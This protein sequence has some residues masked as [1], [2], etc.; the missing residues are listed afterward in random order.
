VKLGLK[1][2]TVVCSDFL[3]AKRELLNDMINKVNRVSLCMFGVNF[4]CSDPG[5]IVDRSILEASGFLPLLSYESQ[6]LNVHL[7]MMPRDLFVVA[8]C[9]DLAHTR[10]AGKPVDAM[11]FQHSRDRRIGY[12]DAV[13]TL[14]IPNNPHGPEMVFAPEMEDFLLDLNWRSV[15]MPF[16]DWWAVYET[17]FA[18]LHVGLAP[19]V[20]T[21]PANPKVTA[22]LGHMS[23][24]VGISKNA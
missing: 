15:C 9:V 22:C 19:A 17:I 11:T 24:L 8:F 18:I 23:G 16:R 7:N 2:V 20:K 14:K 1:F 5:R 12:F 21:G 10:T 3:N 13:I 4:E 6:E